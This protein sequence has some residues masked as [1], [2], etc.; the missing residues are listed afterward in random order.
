GDDTYLVNSVGDTV[1]EVAGGGVDH[2]RSSVGFNLLATPAVENLTLT[3]AASLSG[4]GN[5]L[6]NVLTGNSGANILSGLSG[7]DRLIGNAGNDTLLGGDDKDSLDGGPG[8]DLLD[9][10]GD[11][12][13]MA[14][15]PGNDVYVVDGAG[16]GPLG[17]IVDE[18]AGGGIDLIRSVVDFDLTTTPEVEHLTLLGSAV[19]GA[20]NGHGNIVTGNENANIIGGGDGADTLIGL[21]G[22][23]ILTG[24][25]G[26]DSFVYRSVADSLPQPGPGAPTFDRIIDFTQSQSDHV[27]LRDVDA[28]ADTAA[29]DAFTFI[30][31]APFDSVAGQ[32]RF[33][34]TPVGTQVEGDVDGNG[35]ADF[36]IAFDGRVTFA[37]GDF[38]L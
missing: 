7:L 11:G 2:I 17:D 13:F 10:G 34:F 21:A 25:A 19:T 18:A 26:A 9:G 5:G 22:G 8:D 6:D 30:A 14:G 27:N 16:P 15:G 32:L 29:N 20:G 33:A 37:A 12:D 28:I 31:T 36:L 3:G 4:T 1:L 24:G 23:D 35:S 38:V